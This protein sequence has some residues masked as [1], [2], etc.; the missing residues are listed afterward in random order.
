M[1]MRLRLTFCKNELMRFTGHL[2]LHHTWE[3]TFRRAGLP[4]AYS[5]GFSPHPRINLAS[6]LPLGFTSTAELVDVW[7]EADLPLDEILTA[8]MRACP[9]G[10]QITQIE[11]V[12]ERLPSLQSAVAA[13]EFETTFLA[14]PEDLST[15]LE[16]LMQAETLPRERR[17]K[18]YDLRPL[19]L[20]LEQIA[21]DTEHQPRLRMVLSA[22]ESATGRPEEVLACLG[23]QAE[24]CRVQRTRLIF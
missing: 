21:D 22:R 7:L 10:I 24:D 8:L 15:R 9:P 4:L 23:S 20:E 18:L 13:S 5:Q 2:D 12:D 3:R 19:I 11:Q 14:P 17:G 1:R 16:Q 6:A